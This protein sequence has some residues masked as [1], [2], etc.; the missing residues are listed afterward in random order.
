MIHKN[1]KCFSPWFGY[2]V[3]LVVCIVIAS[4]IFFE[5]KGSRHSRR[6]HKTVPPKPVAM[7]QVA[8]PDE[9]S[10]IDTAKGKVL[11]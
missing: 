9:Q 4:A 3:I 1:E 8:F 5:F 7:Q 6:R 2:L 10:G 11:F